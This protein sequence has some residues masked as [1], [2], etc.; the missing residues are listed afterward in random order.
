MPLNPNLLKSVVHA[1]MPSCNMPTTAAD[2]P[3]ANVQNNHRCERGCAC[4]DPDSDILKGSGGWIQGCNC[5]AA[6]IATT[7]SSWR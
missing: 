7:R 2:D 5:Q 6:L 1:A 3:K 4:T